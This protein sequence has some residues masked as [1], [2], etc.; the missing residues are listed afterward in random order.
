[1]GYMSM[2]KD[3][4]NTLMKAL[5]SSKDIVNL[6][7]NTNEDSP[8]LPDKS[9]LYDHIYPYPFIPQADEAAKT[10]VGIRLTVPQVGSKTFKTIRL[11]AFIFTHY[12]LM[13]APGGLRI[14]LL[15]DAIDSVL[16]G[17]LDYGLGHV[18]LK[19]IDDVHPAKDYYGIAITYDITDWNRVSAP[20]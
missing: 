9:L 10:Y 7:K 13:R 12:S 1:M 17:S 8:T 4:R 3:Y 18:E 2:F 15:A 16:N 19:D 14:D 11:T 5:C 6:L 20:K